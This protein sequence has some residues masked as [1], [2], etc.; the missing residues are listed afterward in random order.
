MAH[1]LTSKMRGQKMRGQLAN[2][3]EVRRTCPESG[4]RR[5]SQSTAVGPLVDSFD[6]RNL[7]IHV[8]PDPRGDIYA[9]RSSTQSIRFS[10]TGEQANALIQNVFRSKNRYRQTPF[11]TGVV[12]PALIQYPSRHADISLII[13]RRRVI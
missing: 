11:A 3:R 9:W 12:S 4:R 10:S 5:T 7:P 2:Q 1:D 8:Q 13:C 6:R